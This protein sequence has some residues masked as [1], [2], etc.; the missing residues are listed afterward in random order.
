MSDLP[1]VV[2]AP[3]EIF[4]QIGDDY[5]D[6]EEV[7]FDDLDEVT[8]CQHNI[9]P[10]DIAY[11]RRD[12]HERLQAENAKLRKHADALCERLASDHP[13]DQTIGA[14]LP[15]EIYAYRADFPKE[16]SDDK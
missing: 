15:Q 2:G 13:V 14:A 10:T 16:P 4:L 7:Q 9:M 3:D 6:G 11:V 5:I 12:I 1:K 8:W